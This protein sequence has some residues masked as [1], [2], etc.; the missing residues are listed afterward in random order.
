MVLW[1]KNLQVEEQLR[2]LEEV[3]A[4]DFKYHFFEPNFHSYLE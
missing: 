2:G 3:G 4:S 1:Q